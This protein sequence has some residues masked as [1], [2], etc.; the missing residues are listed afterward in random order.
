[1][2]LFYFVELF[3]SSLWLTLVS[4]AILGVAAALTLLPTYQ[5]VLDAAVAGGCSDDLP[6]YSIVAGVWSGM[7]SL[8]EVIGPS[9]GGLI[10]EWYGFPTCS[11]LMA[12]VTFGLALVVLIFF[13]INGQP[14]K[15]VKKDED[16]EEED[17]EEDDEKE[18]DIQDQS[19]RTEDS[20][21]LSERP[22]QYSSLH[23]SSYGTL[24][25]ANRD[26]R[27]ASDILKTVALTATGAIEV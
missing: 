2:Y 19:Q 9:V 15:P 16:D 14:V 11:T 5:A 22:S 12:A 7:Y 10:Q 17:E 3:F 24:Q 27:P 1:L 26:T 13:S 8:G 4:L 21:L 18:E 6:T 20:P 25:E 23:N